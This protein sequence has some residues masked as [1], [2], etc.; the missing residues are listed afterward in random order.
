VGVIG[1]RGDGAQVVLLKPMAVAGEANEAKVS[2]RPGVTE[3]D[4]DAGGDAGGPIV[5]KP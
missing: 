2:R 1:G 3:E 5:S 4:G